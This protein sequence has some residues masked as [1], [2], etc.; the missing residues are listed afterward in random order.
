MSKETAYTVAT[1]RPSLRYDRTRAIKH[2]WTEGEMMEGTERG[3]SA[4][5]L[6]ISTHK[7]AQLSPP[8]STDLDYP[9]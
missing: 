1:H 3:P 6:K 4:K 9:S 2:R 8:P 5:N 7:R